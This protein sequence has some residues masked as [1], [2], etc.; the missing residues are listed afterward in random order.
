MQNSTA[1]VE[2]RNYSLKREIDNLKKKLKK[3]EDFN[4]V[5]SLKSARFEI[6]GLIVSASQMQRALVEA[7]MRMKLFP[8]AA[9]IDFNLTRLNH[10]RHLMEGEKRRNFYNNPIAK[11]LQRIE[12]S[13][14]FMDM[15]KEWNT[16]SPPRS[17]DNTSIDEKI[18]RLGNQL[19]NPELNSRL[20]RVVKV[21]R[22]IQRVPGMENLLARHYLPFI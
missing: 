16:I 2:R 15:Y 11:S 18:E 10:V 9:V 7:Y 14:D 8:N 5:L 6:N 12:Y 19:L 3:S 13:E 4:Q 21:I 17:I 1:K 22:E 20:G